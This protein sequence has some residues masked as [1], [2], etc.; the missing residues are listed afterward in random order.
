MRKKEK[1]KENDIYEAALQIVNEEGIAGLKM[2]KLASSA[3]LS[4]GTLYVYFKDKETL[5]E[6]MNVHF[7][8]R[9]FDESIRWASADESFEN[10]FRTTWFNYMR[11]LQRNPRVIVFLEQF[12]NEQVLANRPLGISFE[13]LS[14][15]T[16]LIKEGQS[17]GILIPGPLQVHLALLT[18]AS[19]RWVL[20]SMQN[21]LPATTDFVHLAWDMIWGA[22]KR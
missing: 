19:H 18:A 3:G 5:L 15:F 17:L 22:I 4:V 21:W 20:W 14:P 10:R 13:Q 9:L 6:S 11:L 12:Q 2:Q 7:R 8:Q 16:Q 1:K